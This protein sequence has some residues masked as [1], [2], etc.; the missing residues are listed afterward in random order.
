MSRAP[1]PPGA[2]PRRCSDRLIPLTVMPAKSGHPGVAR[3]AFV[4]WLWMPAFAGMTVSWDARDSISGRGLRLR[5]AVLDHDA[6]ARIVLGGRLV[7][8]DQARDGF[9]GG[10]AALD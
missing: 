6:L 4:R 3:R 7:V 5:R 2:T 10:L 1:A 8:A 9:Q